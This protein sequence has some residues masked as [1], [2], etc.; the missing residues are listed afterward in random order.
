MK[1]FNMF[2]MSVT[3]QNS[4][5]NYNVLPSVRNGK[6]NQP[7]SPKQSSITMVLPW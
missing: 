7:K 6:V 3:C 1:K 5:K 2:K 4:Y